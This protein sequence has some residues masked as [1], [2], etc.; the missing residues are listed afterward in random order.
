MQR[1]PL[2]K[3]NT[4][5]YSSAL[6]FPLLSLFLYLSLTPPNSVKLLCPLDWLIGTDGKEK[7]K[8]WCV[9]GL[10]TNISF[11]QWIQKRLWQENT[12]LRFL[13]TEKIRRY[14]W[15]EG[16]EEGRGRGRGERK[17]KESQ[18]ARSSPEALERNEITMTCLSGAFF[19]SRS[20]S[21]KQGFGFYDSL[22]SWGPCFCF[23]TQNLVNC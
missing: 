19:S 16:R 22:G 14:T 12:E 3:F 1:W 17:G 11:L 6:R 5:I 9:G 4:V 7:V 15:V 2:S 10:F 8:L 18:L 13:K 23:S 21:R 20:V